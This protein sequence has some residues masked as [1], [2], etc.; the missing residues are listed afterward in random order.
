MVSNFY[1]SVSNVIL[2]TLQWIPKGDASRT[3]FDPM[4]DNND[5]LCY[6]PLPRFRPHLTHTLAELFKCIAKCA[7]TIFL[8]LLKK[9]RTFVLSQPVSECIAPRV[10]CPNFKLF[11]VS[12]LLWISVRETERGVCRL[13]IA[14][15]EFVSYW[16]PMFRAL[17][18]VMTKVIKEKLT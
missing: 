6:Y 9:I 5:L 13:V 4:I 15:V 14:T 18:Q 10:Y 12:F 16:R 11:L 17:R 2:L 7:C 8:L 1:R 3:V